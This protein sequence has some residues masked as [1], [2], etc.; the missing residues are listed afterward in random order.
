MSLT[1]APCA[2]EGCHQAEAVEAGQQDVGGD[3]DGEPLP[4]QPVGYEIGDRP[5]V[6]DDEHAHGRE[7]TPVAPLLHGT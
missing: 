3:I 4:L 2:A 5:V 1:M 6:L 7:C